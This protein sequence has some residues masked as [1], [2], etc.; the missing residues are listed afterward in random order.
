MK[1]PKCGQECDL[2]ENNEPYCSNEECPIF[3]VGFEDSLITDDEEEFY[4]QE[5][6]EEDEEETDA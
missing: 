6:E 5:D 2:D 3:M 4:D 1:C